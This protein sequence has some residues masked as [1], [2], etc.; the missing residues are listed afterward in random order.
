M[1]HNKCKAT[2]TGLNM[3]VIEMNKAL[4][5]MRSENIELTSKLNTCESAC[6]K[7]QLALKNIAA[8]VG[9]K[10]KCVV[11]MLTELDHTLVDELLLPIVNVYIEIRGNGASQ[12]SLI[13]NA[14]AN[15]VLSIL[16]TSIL[17]AKTER[18][19]IV[20]MHM[21]YYGLI[22]TGRLVGSLDTLSNN[23]DKILSII[24]KSHHKQVSLLEHNSIEFVLRYDIR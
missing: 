14:I 11:A 13:G 7:Q 6:N 24:A 19:N 2:I 1:F 22:I 21:G 4:D 5:E 3:Q 17:G 8:I 9:N 16:K 10:D 23:I 12:R 18:E 15:A 20:N